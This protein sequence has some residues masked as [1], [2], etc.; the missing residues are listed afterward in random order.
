V[1]ERSHPTIAAALVALTVILS[2][3]ACGGSS[4]S[5]PAAPTPVVAPPSTSAADPSDAP[6]PSAP[7]SPLSSGGIAAVEAGLLDLLPAQVV[8]V[9]LTPDPETAAE[10][11]SD[12]VVS[13]PLTSLAVAAAFGPLATE[14][15]GDY[16]V[17]TIVR[18]RSGTFSESFFRD[19]RDT[20]D[21]A[22]C[23]QAGGV[24]GHAEAE[25]GGHRTWIGTCAGDVHT[26]HATLQ[27]GEVIVSLQGAGPGRYGEQVVAGLTE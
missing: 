22:V 20:F 18:L 7:P 26:Y 10:L 25:I 24:T 23:A 11:A 4:P 15:P 14:G 1:T 17:V 3:T 16:A 5:A 12:P 21:E 9:P 6:T 27:D 19:W 2:I 13:R 8:G